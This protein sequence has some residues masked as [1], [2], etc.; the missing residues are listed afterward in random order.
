[1]INDLVDLAVEEHDHATNIFLQW[2]VSEQVEEEDS[3]NEVAQKIKL[4]GDARGGL[5]VL[6]RELG[7]RV[8][9]P[10]TTDGGLKG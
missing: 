4:A 10:P 2:F 1:L 9:I 3:A 8:F 5:F 6:D 7:Q